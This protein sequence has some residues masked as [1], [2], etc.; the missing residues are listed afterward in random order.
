MGTAATAIL[1]PRLRDLVAGQ[2]GS[3]EICASIPHRE[4]MLLFA[5]GDRAHRDEMRALVREK[6]SD[7]RKPLTFEL[8]ELTDAGPKPLAGR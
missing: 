6:E 7:G 5:K 4:A 3:R 1:L 2:V 8:F